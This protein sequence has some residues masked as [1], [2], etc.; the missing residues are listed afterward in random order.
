MSAESVDI[1][2]VLNDLAEAERCSGDFQ[3]AEQDYLEAPR[4]AREIGFAEGLADIT[5]GLAKLAL[6]R[7]D[8]SSAESLAGEALSLSEDVGRLELIAS[9]CRRI[10]EA[11]VRQGKPVEAL[12]YAQRSVEIFTRLGSPDIEDA[13]ATLAECEA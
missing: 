6:S 13:C 4:M 7:E 12:P 1:V 5:G 2:T 3:A 9:N 10:A 8:W 11:I